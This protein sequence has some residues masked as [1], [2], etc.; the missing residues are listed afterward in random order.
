MKRIIKDYKN[1]TPE[2]L[3]I[4]NDKYPE[5]IDEDDFI[6]FTNHLGE[7]VKAVEIRYED[8]IYLIKVSRQLT[9]KMD[10][11]LD[12]DEDGDDDSLETDFE[13]DDAA[14]DDVKVEVSDD[15]DDDDFD[16]KDDDEE[17]DED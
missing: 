10:E 15:D 5:G 7:T 4:L 17:E 12:D 6:S 3:N 9:A 13:E 14:P 16:D 1:I 8:D 11:A 2:L